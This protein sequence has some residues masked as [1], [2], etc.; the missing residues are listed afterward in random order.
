MGMGGHGYGHPMLGY[1]VDGI[2]CDLYLRWTPKRHMLHWG[3]TMCSKHITHYM[4]NNW[5]NCE[6]STYEYIYIYIYTYIH[7]G[8]SL[9]L[10]YTFMSFLHFKC[11]SKTLNRQSSRFTV[12]NHMRQLDLIFIWCNVVKCTGSWECPQKGHAPLHINTYLTHGTRSKRVEE[13]PKKVHVQ[14]YSIGDHDAEVM[15]SNLSYK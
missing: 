9:N 7:K 12:A 8:F 11:V 3:W 1:D 4:F 10:V 2:W 6:W 5:H 14:L 13:V 15:W